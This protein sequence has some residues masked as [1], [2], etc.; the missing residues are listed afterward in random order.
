MRGDVENYERAYISTYYSLNKSQHN[1][2]DTQKLTLLF[3]ERVVK[4]FKTHRAAIN[5][6]A[7]FMNGFVCMFDGVMGA[8]QWL[9]VASLRRRF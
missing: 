3:I 6:D 7:S 4:A 5:W 2:G 9:K 1:V 8:S